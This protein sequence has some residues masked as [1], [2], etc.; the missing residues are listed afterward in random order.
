VWNSAISSGAAHLGIVSQA[1]ACLGAQV[2]GGGVVSVGFTVQAFRPA[3]DVGAGQS[4]E[5]VVAE[6]LGLALP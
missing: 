5:G 4:V 6:G 2:A 1:Q 3:G